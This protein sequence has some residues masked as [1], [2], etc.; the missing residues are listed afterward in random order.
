MKNIHLRIVT[1]LF[2]ISGLTSLIYQIYWQKKIFT[3]LGSDIYATS[4]NLSAFML[5][6]SLGSYLI[7]I[8]VDN[9]KYRIVIYGLIEILIGVFALQFDII[10]SRLTPFLHN[11][12]NLFFLSNPLYYHSIKFILLFL[13]LLIPTMLMGATLPLLIREL[14]PNINLLGT[15]T[16]NLYSLNT[17]GAMFGV[18]FS[19]FFL[20]YHFGMEMT[21]WIAVTLNLLVGLFAILLYGFK[22]Q[23]SEL[24]LEEPSI[25]ENNNKTNFNDVNFNIPLSTFIIGFSILSMEVIWTRIQVQYFSAT[26]HS[27]SIM[28]FFVLLGLYWGSTLSKKFIDKRKDLTDIFTYLILA[29]GIAISF[30]GLLLYILPSLYIK[31]VFSLNSIFNNKDSW[32]L[33]TIISKS[34]CASL[35]ILFPC[36]ISGIL[37]PIA[38]KI[39]SNSNQSIGKT[40]SVVYYWNTIGSVL[41]PL[42][43]AFILIPL[44]NIKGAFFAISLFI[45]L[46]GTL[47]NFKQTKL[48]T[49]FDIIPIVIFITI[50]SISYLLPDKIV[51]NYSIIAKETELIYHEEGNAQTISLLK[52][53]KNQTIFLIDGNV[54]A[55]NSPTQLRHFI[56]KGHLPLLLHPQPD[57]VLVIGLG[58]G[59]T[60]NAIENNPAVKTIDLVELS[61]Q[62]VK[63]QEY[64]ININNDV[65]NNEKLNLIIDDG[66][67]FLSATTKKYDM[68]TVD[69][70]HPRIS[71]VGTLYTHEFYEQV[72]EHLNHNG[73]YIQWIPSYQM[74][75]HSFKMAVNTFKTTFPHSILW[76]VKGHVLLLG[77]KNNIIIDYDIMKKNFYNI[78]SDM[79]RINIRNTEELLSLVAMTPDYLN[80]YTE[81]FNMQNNDNNLYLEYH[82][83]GQ[84]LYNV[85]DIIKS[86]LPYW[87]FS[88]VYIKNVNQE[89]RNTIFAY[90]DERETKLR[91]NTNNIIEN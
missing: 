27:F 7:G 49:A 3:L 83:P 75:P 1:Y 18:F 31:F 63:A 33:I 22:S 58:M 6:L 61:P 55:D 52:N 79:K 84:Y 78:S 74:S 30:T 73:I 65:L 36:I 40:T 32:F 90:W 69:P 66:R 5:G 34:I 9:I 17:L 21:L 51:S 59:I 23:L 56:L 20:I 44:L 19:G 10:I 71:G 14:T 77:K 39:S 57:N 25:D 42:T 12:Y 11:T 86:I 37:F 88:D 15:I 91:L 45:I 13:I 4:M 82:V 47:L 67:N 54:E 26:V 62:V 29:M 70:I 81:G 38:V 35:F 68:I 76:Y 46:T 80:L 41:G 87:G 43:T 24:K 85:D 72:S 60:L 50:I 16:A 28:L 53:D 8:F 89:E 2:F 48:Y 64:L